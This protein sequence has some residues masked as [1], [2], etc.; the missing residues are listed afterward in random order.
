M[1]KKE[2][3]IWLGKR[4][5]IYQYTVST[6]SPVAYAWTYA[7][8]AYPPRSLRKRRW[9]YEFE[10]IEAAGKVYSAEFEQVFRWLMDR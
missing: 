5:Y 4:S 1:L 8:S 10:V 6:H 2:S 7:D 3:L 9:D